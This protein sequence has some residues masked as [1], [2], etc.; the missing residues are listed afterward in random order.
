[1]NRRHDCP[2]CGR[3]GVLYS[4]VVCRRCWLDLPAGLAA[5]L[6]DTWRCRTYQP[7]EYQE[8]LAAALLWRQGKA[9]GPRER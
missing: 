6:L 8:S 1:V 7:R 4:M 9:G 5:P 2:L 3:A